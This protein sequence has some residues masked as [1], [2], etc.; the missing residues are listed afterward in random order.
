M[1]L[2]NTIANPTITATTPTSN[3]PAAFV[4]FAEA[5]VPVALPDTFTTPV[6]LAPA[7]AIL[8]PEAIDVAE[9]LLEPDADADMEEMEETSVATHTQVSSHPICK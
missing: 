9:D 5:A 2:Y 6:A 4:F 7:V 3:L 1:P 8:A